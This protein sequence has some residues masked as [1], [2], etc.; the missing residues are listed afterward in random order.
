MVMLYATFLPFIRC[1][2]RAAHS[3][4]SIV[5][6]SKPVRKYIVLRLHTS[7]VVR[8]QS[9]SCI[10]SKMPQKMKQTRRIKKENEK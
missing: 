8:W 6:E 2:R 9:Q 1:G 5:I 10:Q 7:Y 4:I 3:G